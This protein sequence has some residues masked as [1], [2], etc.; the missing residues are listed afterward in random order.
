MSY[1]EIYRD[2]DYIPVP[3][4]FKNQAFISEEVFRDQISFGN[5]IMWNRAGEWRKFPNAIIVDVLHTYDM[6][7]H[8]PKEW[9]VKPPAPVGKLFWDQGHSPTEIPTNDA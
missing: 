6:W 3:D 9:T 4:L 8:A 1:L 5:F 7:K 2:S